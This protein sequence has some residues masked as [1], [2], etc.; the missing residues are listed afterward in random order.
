[1]D[2]LQGWVH[3]LTGHGEKPAIIAFQRTDLTTWSFRH[4]VEQARRLAGGVTEAGLQPRTHAILFAPNTPEWAVACVALFAAAAVPVPLDAQ[5]SE[6]DL[7]HVVADSEA[8]WI[9]TTMPLAQRLHALG[10]HHDKTLVFLDAETEHPQ[11]WQHSL[12]EPAHEFPSAKPD[13]LAV[14]FYT[15]GTTGKPK[16]VPLTHRNLT[17]NLTALLSLGLIRADERV[18][19]PLPLHHVYPFTVGFL[20]PLATGVPI[21]LPRS[22]TGPQILRALRDGHVTAILGVPRFYAAL[23]SAI[24]A[25]VRR[26]GRLA[27]A[28]FSAG[29]AAS[30]A[31]QRRLGLRLGRWV[32]APLHKQ[33]A[34]HLRIVASGGAALDPDLAWQ[35]EGLGW[36]VASGYGLT[37]TSPILTFHAP[38]AGRLD[39]AASPCPALTSA[40]PNRKN[41]AR[42]GK[43]WR[44]DRMSFRGTGIGRRKRARSS[45]PTATSAPGTSAGWTKTGTSTWWAGPRR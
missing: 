13:D 32:F 27:A 43:S 23:L 29:L 33:V 4:L 14:L 24:T 41:I 7:R 26:R 38:G 31:L 3:T 17:A 30:V 36:Q 28:A 2:T 45:P 12:A 8:R 42:R 37:E 10:L 5:M 18:L 1:M 15:S 25:R 20:A 6:E 35:L 9:F 22:L 40:S 19:L 44:R 39:T 21:L 11:S 34:P 16:G